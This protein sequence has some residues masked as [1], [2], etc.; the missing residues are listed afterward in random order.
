MAAGPTVA[1]IRLGAF[2]Q[3]MRK[4]TGL[5][6][7]DAAR[8]I[9]GSAPKISKI[10]NGRNAVLTKD[11]TALLKLYKVTDPAV[12]EEMLALAK[13]SREDDWYAPLSKEISVNSRYLLALEAEASLLSVFEQGAVPALLQ[14]DRYARAVTASL[15]PGGQAWRAAGSRNWR[16]G[17]GIMVLARRR[18]LLK[19]PDPPQL[20][21]LIQRAALTRSPS[22]DP[23]VLGNQL[24]ELRNIATSRE[25]QRRITIQIVPDSAGALLSAPGPFTMLKFSHP[26][27]PSVVL[28]EAKTTIRSSTAP[29]ELDHHRMI[30]NGLAVGAIK[31]RDTPEVLDQ[32]I[33]QLPSGSAPAGIPGR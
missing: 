30:F 17:L 2:M 31:P 32:I 20:W 18:G 11:V 27:V 28:T 6:G 21:V 26:D 14:T 16:G 12:R 22:E 33:G 3:R 15:N 24:A 4:Q 13:L 1:R 9:G 8:A 25:M 7:E 19:L 23:A 29:G 10:E 5:S